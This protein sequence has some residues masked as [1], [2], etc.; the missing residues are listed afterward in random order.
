MKQLLKTEISNN[1]VTVRNSNFELLRILC[2]LFI[3]MHHYTVHCLAKL[4]TVD[5]SF[6]MEIYNS[7][8][9]PSGKIAVNIFILISAYFLVSKK[10]SIKR[11]YSLI[12]QTT[13]YA[14]LGFTLYS[15]LTNTSFNFTYFIHSLLP[16]LFNEYWFA[17]CYFVLLLIFPLLNIIINNISKKT[18]LLIIVLSL[19]FTILLPFV[20]GTNIFYTNYF[21]FIILYF[22]GSYIKLY[23]I[24]TN[25]LPTIIALIFL[26]IAQIL[27]GQYCNHDDWYNQNTFINFFISILIFLLFQNFQF[28][29]K[30]INTIAKFSF[31]VYLIHDNPYLR[32]YLWDFIAS[33]N[34]TTSPFFLLYA[35]G[36]SISIFIICLILDLIKYLAIEKPISFAYKKIKHCHFKH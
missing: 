34:I 2:M 1:G 32:P 25:S 26:F 31:G 14:L 18:H 7:I 28:Q 10:F 23:N 3:V 16:L 30:L 27:I 33:F 12:F 8:A 19:V 29:S 15:I 6:Q 9:G 13:F 4:S 17:T 11:F 36:I 24:K 20:F 35:L 22:V 5:Y 21:W